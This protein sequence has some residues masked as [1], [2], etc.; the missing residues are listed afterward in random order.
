M[1]ELYASNLKLH[2]KHSKLPTSKWQCFQAFYVLHL[3]DHKELLFIYW[4]NMAAVIMCTS[5]EKTRHQY[6]RIILHPCSTDYIPSLFI[7]TFL[8]MLFKA[9]HS[10]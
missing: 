2:G 5:L 1:T 9:L 6:Q 8:Y 7:H 3:H 10:M 4:D